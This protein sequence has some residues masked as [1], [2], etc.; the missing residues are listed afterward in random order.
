MVKVQAHRARKRL[1]AMLVKSGGLRGS[2]K[3]D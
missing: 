3:D 1:R 2:T